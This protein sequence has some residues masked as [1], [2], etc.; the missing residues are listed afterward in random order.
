MQSLPP[1]P[2]NTRVGT[3]VGNR[4]QLLRLLGAGAMGAVYEAEHVI[5]GHH[6]A[7]KLLTIGDA[8]STARFLR[9][10]AAA[11]RIRHRGVVQ[12][13]D[14][15]VDGD[16]LFVVQELLVGEDLARRIERA[17]L[18]H[19]QVSRIFDAVLDALEGAHAAGLVHRDI[20]PANI[21]LTSD[22]IPRVMLVDFGVARD[23]AADAPAITQAGALVGSPAYLSP[24]QV[25]GRPADPRSDLWA[26]GVTLYEALTG[27]LPWRSKTLYALLA[28][29]AGED[30]IQLA[31]VATEIPAALV[32]SVAGALRREPSARWQSAPAMRRALHTDPDRATREVDPDAPDPEWNFH[33]SFKG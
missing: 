23:L 7:L 1:T 33:R 22:A 15:G 19:H 4:Y 31:E 27:R 9:E 24:E 5:T 26:V 12:V 3:L 14:A 29:I 20:K 6:H 11:A 28:E 32:A 25:A 17:P 18:P 10:A 13:T 21:F 30:P 2:I 16:V 8:A